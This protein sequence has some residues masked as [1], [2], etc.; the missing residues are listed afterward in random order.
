MFSNYKLVSYEKEWIG[1]KLFKYKKCKVTFYLIINDEAYNLI[2]IHDQITGRYKLY[3]NDKL[4]YSER[5]ILDTGIIFDFDHKIFNTNP[6]INIELRVT[7][8]SFKK[9]FKNFFLF[10]YSIFVNG[11]DLK[12]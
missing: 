4:I 2:L 1:G 10:N 11:N 8:K 3:L 5:W 9:K 6:V 7:Y 12:K